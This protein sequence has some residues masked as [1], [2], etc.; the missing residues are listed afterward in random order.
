VE[1]GR[2][3]ARAGARATVHGRVQ[4]V[5]YRYSAVRE[6]RRLGLQGTVANQPDGSVAV[7]AEGSPAAL[8][9]FLAWLHQGPPGARVTSVDV[10]PVPATGR[11]QGFEVAF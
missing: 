8:A 7:E 3:G 2:A 1:P 5:G 11:F 10:E 6:A 4:G 9:E